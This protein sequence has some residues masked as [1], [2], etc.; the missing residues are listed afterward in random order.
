MGGVDNTD[1]SALIEAGGTASEIR[2]WEV[3]RKFKIEQT[4]W[5][6]YR[7]A[8]PNAT[9]TDTVRAEKLD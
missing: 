4:D 8:N 6:A 1:Y 7:E 9:W 5:S 2:L 3:L